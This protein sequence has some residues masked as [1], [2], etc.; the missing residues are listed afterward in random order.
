MSEE[1]E[2]KQE[3][4]KKGVKLLVLG[5]AGSGKTTLL[6]TLKD[7]L[8][9]SYDN[10]DF[11]IKSDSI[12]HRNIHQKVHGGVLTTGDDFVNRLDS[13]LT[14]YIAKKNK[15]PKTLVIDS[16]STVVGAINTYCNDK[17][18]GFKQWSEYIKNIQT[19]NNILTTLTTKG[20]NVIL[21]SHAQ[22]NVQ[23]DKWEDTTKGSFNKSEGGFLATVD[24]S[25]FIESTKTDERIIH[26]KNSYKLARTTLDLGDNEKKVEA[27]KFSLQAY[28]DRIE[29]H[30]LEASKYEI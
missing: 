21:V 16:I 29:Q 7:A 13:L 14:A 20:I 30:N 19:I 17:F 5:T 25:L 1:K 26:L 4:V 24:Y 3:E 2:Q 6:K 10:K 28:L 22:Y 11:P 27:S 15:P 9:F 8:V 18:D 12:V 23:N